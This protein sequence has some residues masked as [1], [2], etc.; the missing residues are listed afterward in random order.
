MNVICFFSVSNTV[1]GT[2]ATLSATSPLT[3]TKKDGAR[4]GGAKIKNDAV[5]AL[6]RS[7]VQYVHKSQSCIR[8]SHDRLAGIYAEI[9]IS[10]GD[11]VINGIYN[12]FDI[13]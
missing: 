8:S 5:T 9:Q 10:L 11:C 4:G 6:V 13:I 7:T 2:C 1:L 12:L 3:R